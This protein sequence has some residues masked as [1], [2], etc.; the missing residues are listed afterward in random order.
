MRADL[1]KP[2]SWL[3][4]AAAIALLVGCTPASTATSGATAGPTS[5]AAGAASSGGIQA[6]ESE[7][8]IALSSATASTGEVTFHVK[9]AGTQ[10]HEFVVVRTE[11]AA[12]KLPLASDAP[13]VDE[14]ATGLTVVDEVEDLAAGASTDLTVTLEAGHYAVICNVPGH[15]T[16]GMHTDFTAGG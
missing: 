12:D 4:L 13:E 10:V 11:L 16:L 14:E 2:S 8:K 15:Y 9:N 5:A 1:G 3:A 6:S 7:F